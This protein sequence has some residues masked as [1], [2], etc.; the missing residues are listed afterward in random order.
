MNAAS[1]L[2]AMAKVLETPTK[3]KS[4]NNYSLQSELFLAELN[5]CSL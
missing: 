4:E 3:T 2:A 1:K 5:C